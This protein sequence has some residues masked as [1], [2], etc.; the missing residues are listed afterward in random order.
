MKY[1]VFDSLY[2]LLE[3]ILEVY[4]I[5]IVTIILNLCMFVKENLWTLTSLRESFSP[6][7]L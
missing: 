2:S 4:K 7:L 3:L 1:I 6:L 5:I